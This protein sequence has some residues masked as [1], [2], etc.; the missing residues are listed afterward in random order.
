MNAFFDDFHDAMFAIEDDT[1]ETKRDV[2]TAVGA[3][4]SRTIAETYL[5]AHCAALV[6]NLGP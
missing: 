3:A 1:V 4:A 2:N 6:D 5:N